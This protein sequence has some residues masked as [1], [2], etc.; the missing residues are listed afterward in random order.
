MAKSKPAQLYII[1]LENSIA[2]YNVSSIVFMYSV[3]A[4]AWLHSDITSCCH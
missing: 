4:K 2:S 1:N 3:Y